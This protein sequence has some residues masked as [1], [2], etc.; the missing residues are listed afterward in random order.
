MTKLGATEIITTHINF[1]KE[2][3]SD[4]FFKVFLNVIKGLHTGQMSH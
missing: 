4:Q 2:I 1:C 3:H